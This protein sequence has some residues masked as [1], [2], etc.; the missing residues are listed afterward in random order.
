MLQ[1]QFSWL[2]IFGRVKRQTL[3]TTATT[4]ALALVEVTAFVALYNPV[5]DGGLQ[6]VSI[7]TK[8]IADAQAAGAGTNIDT[9]GSLKV[10]GAD[11]FKYDL[12]LP[13][14]DLAFVTG[15]GAIDT[16]AGAMVAFTDQFLVG[17]DWRVNNRTPTEITSVISGQLDK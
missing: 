5:A 1:V 3:T 16:G 17:G 15:G 13:M 6:D 2:D 9:N 12:N 14:I 7:S 10:Q 11:G 4:I 8:S